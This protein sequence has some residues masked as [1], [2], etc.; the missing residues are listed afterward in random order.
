LTSRPLP[1]SSHDP[2]NQTRGD[3][4]GGQPDQESW[5]SSSLIL[6]VRTSVRKYTPQ[7]RYLSAEHFEPLRPHGF[8]NAVERPVF[9]HRTK[10]NRWP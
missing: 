9:D 6:P 3:A 8:L 1:K 2:R 10:L 7:V 4:A 5:Q